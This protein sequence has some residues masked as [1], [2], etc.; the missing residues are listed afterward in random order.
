MWQ[1]R[2]DD[3]ASM[4]NVPA[5]HVQG[6][7]SSIYDRQARS[8]DKWSKALL[9][10]VLAYTSTTQGKSLAETL[11]AWGNS[12]RELAKYRPEFKLDPVERG[13]LLSVLRRLCTG[14]DKEPDGIRN[15]AVSTV[16]DQFDIALTPFH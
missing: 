11:R 1:A 13:T 12:L 16:T 14:I 2:R 8:T 5:V 3:L 10:R 7:G 4:V 9:T 6:L 15:L